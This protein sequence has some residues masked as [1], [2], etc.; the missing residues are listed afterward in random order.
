M[1]PLY[2]PHLVKLGKEESFL[3][4][5]CYGNTTVTESQRHHY[6][7]SSLHRRKYCSCLQ[8]EKCFL[9]VENTATTMER[10]FL[11]Y[12][13]LVFKKNIIGFKNMKCLTS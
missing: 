5:T 10:C 1:I 12:I 3:K 8:D 2:L 9:P 6:D 7:G 4:A 11:K 13:L